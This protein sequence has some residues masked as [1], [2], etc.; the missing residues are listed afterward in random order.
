[1]DRI[2]LALP[3]G[4]SEKSYR[5]PAKPHHDPTLKSAPRY[6]EYTFWIDCDV[7]GTFTL[8][9]RSLSLTL[10]LDARAV[11][12]AARRGTGKNLIDLYQHVLCLQP[13]WRVIAYH[14]GPEAQPL[15]H[16]H[17]QPRLLHCPADRIDAWRRWRLPAA[18]WAD[19]VNLLHCPANLAPSWMPVPV[20][21]TIHD[22]LPLQGPARLARALE[23]SIRRCIAQRS[24]IITPS[25]Y[26][27]DELVRRFA[28]DP[29]HIAVNPWAADQSM[30]LITDDNH[31]RAV[32]L[33]YG[34]NDR[35]ILHLGAPDPRKNTINALRAYARL[36]RSVRMDTP[37]LVIGLDREDHRRQMTD[38][39]TQLDITDCVRLNGFADEA[40]MP[41]LF[42]LAKVLLYPS[43]A[44]GF[45]L[46]ILDAWATKTAVL[47][48]HITS[49]PEVGADAVLY[50]DPEN[51]DDIAD[52][53]H[54]LVRDDV[55]RD[56]LIDAGTRRL[57][58][59]TW[60][61]TAQRFIDAVQLALSIE[62]PL[63][64]KE[65]RRDAA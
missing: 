58:Q 38:L 24:I 17:Y 9:G 22:L 5:T 11:H 36:P 33:K 51:H 46:P 7:W 1:M 16:R 37:L 47:T 31:L 57:G 65:S 43:R 4:L 63:Q 48:S 49:L 21:L 12:R 45:G 62:L 55:L 61:L 13:D 32:A 35:P 23:A 15:N 19:H 14:R 10:G 44:E 54:A 20:L 8:N 26:T 28:A 64:R 59:F 6:P 30:Q 39:C 2:A 52:R 60:T 34:L 27:A 25:H 3:I 41:A 18:A 56:S 50:A 42:S 29:Q 40:D 53:L